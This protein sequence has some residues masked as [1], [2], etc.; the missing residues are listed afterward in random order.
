M[1]EKVKEYSFCTAKLEHDKK[2][3]CLHISLLKK[4]KVFF[5]STIQNVQ[6]SFAKVFLQKCTEED[7]KDLVKNEMTIL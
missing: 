2:K 7:I 6:S 3:Q 5:K 1:S 4:G